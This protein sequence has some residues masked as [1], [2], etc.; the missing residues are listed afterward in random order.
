MSK[1]KDRKRVE[2]KPGF[3]KSSPAHE[4]EHLI[5]KGRLKDAVKQAKICYRDECTPE[6]HRL[7]ERAYFLRTQ[8]LYRDAM[9]TSAVEVAQHLL[10]FGVTD[11]T[12]PAELA[13]LLLAIGLPSAALAMGERL[14]SPEAKARLLLNVADQAVLHPERAPAS[15][16][17]IRE[18]AN[19]VREALRALDAG[20]EANALDR[21]RE[22]ARSSPF[23]DWRYFVRGLAAFRRRD[24]EQLQA[25][26]D[27]LDAGRAASRIARALRSLGKGVA[28]TEPH[29]QPTPAPSLKVIE[30]A[31]FGEPLLSQVEQLRQFMAEERWSDLIPLLIP[32]RFHLQRID[33]RLAERLTRILLSPLAIATAKLSPREA[34]ILIGNFV[35]AAEPLPI[36]PHWNRLRAL[37]A[38]G[39]YDDEHDAE[40]FWQAYLVDL[41]TLPTL[42]PEER[43]RAQALVWEHL[44]RF[45]AT[46]A[47]ADEVDRFGAPPPRQQIEYARKR[48]IECLEAS[49]QADP[50]FLEAYRAILTVY[51]NWDQD[52]QAEVAANRLLTVFPNHVE[53]LIWLFDHQIDQDLPEQAVPLIQRARV[54]KPLDEDFRRKEWVAHMALGRHHALKR[55]WDKGRAEFALAEPLWPERSKSYHFLVRQVVFELKAGENDRAEEYLK[56]A[57]EQLVE[58]T[59][60]WLAILIEGVRYRLPKTTMSRFNSLWETG[61][62]QKVKSETAGALAELLTT[63]L[64]SEVKYTGQSKHTKQLVDYLKR[65]T[66]IQYRR[67]DLVQVC[68]FL[69]PERKWHDLL[70]KLVMRG[71]K[72]FPDAAHFPFIVATLEIEKGPY[73]GHLSL[74]LKNLKQALQLAQA[75]S[76]PEEIHLV[77][78]LKKLLAKFEAMDSRPFGMP[79]PGFGGRPSG[80][81]IDMFTEMFSHMFNDDMFSEED[82][83]MWDED[84]DDDRKPSTGPPPAR[85]TRGT[86]KKKSPKKR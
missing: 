75:S 55:R 4:V 47:D 1:H 25:N 33:P 71:L 12:L 65:T 83:D 45:F 16:T 11:P 24:N 80:N 76:N 59:P 38:Q 10:E 39:P 81:P 41:K 64:D 22:I 60:L 69:R 67:E 9:P 61:L 27:R 30:T 70:E 63:Y 66:R 50:T 3:V 84:D 74:V 46:G 20:D 21:L 40:K 35:K 14:E 54:L 29:T 19:L 17:E 82:E 68:N 72:S 79:F 8:Q 62:T 85:P 56:A 5:Q 49:V 18:G 43:Q 34:R 15:L 44:S 32:L 28:A 52:E 78:E 7:L 57:Q 13:P 58:P 53:T 23:A 77:P 2:M 86:P 36:D 37:I 48:T 31:V 26:W 73:R 6:N 42:S 51:S